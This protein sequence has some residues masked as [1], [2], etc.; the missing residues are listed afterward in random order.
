ML[1][2]LFL[3]LPALL[4]L[5][6]QAV[7]LRIAAAADLV[8]CLDDL[9]ALFKKQHPQ[10]DVK[11]LYESSTFGTRVGVGGGMVEGNVGRGNGGV[12]GCCGR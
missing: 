11:L 5:P 4:P 10:A 1:K 8:Y 6:L 7:S 12:L 9:N 3:I 2:R